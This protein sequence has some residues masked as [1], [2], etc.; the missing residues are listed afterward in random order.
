MLTAA[1]HMLKYNADYPD[2]GADHFDRRDKTR[3]AKRLIAQ[4][5][6]LGCKVDYKPREPRGISF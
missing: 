2:L 6:D 1:Y 4:L 5:H 3:L